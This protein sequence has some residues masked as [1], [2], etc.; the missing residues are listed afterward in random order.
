MRM[1]SVFEMLLLVVPFTVFFS[2]PECAQASTADIVFLIDGSSSIDIQNFQEVRRFLRSL[3]SGLDIG[4]D[5]IRVGVAQ[6]SDEPFQEFLLDEHM[7][8]QS[9]LAEVDKIPY[10]MGGTET[11]EAMEFILSQYFTEDA[12]SRAKQRVPQ[13]AVV[14]TDGES[15]DNV[16]EPAQRL[17]DHGVIVF[18][19]GVGDFNQEELESIANRPLHRFLFTIDSYAA[20]QRLTDGLLQTVCVSIESQTQGEAAGGDTHQGLNL[21]GARCFND[22][23]TRNAPLQ[24]L[25][26]L[27]DCF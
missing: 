7:D 20:L 16:T 19:I 26:H 1:D 2:F 23:H 21:A 17:R 3:I 15:A 18:A 11:G 13:F 5:K 24:L 12:G 27:T 6:Y 9:L 25:V 22:V 10:R 8:K 4:P 14:I